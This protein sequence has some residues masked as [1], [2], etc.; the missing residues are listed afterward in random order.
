[1]NGVCLRMRPPAS[2]NAFSRYFLD[3]AWNR[4]A[5]R[6]KNNSMYVNKANCFLAGHLLSRLERNLTDGA[7]LRAGDD[8]PQ[9][10][11]RPGSWS[12]LSGIPSVGHEDRRRN[13]NRSRSRGAQL[14]DTGDMDDPAFSPWCLRHTRGRLPRRCARA[15]RS[16]SL[17]TAALFAAPELLEVFHKL[18]AHVWHP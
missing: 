11:G 9:R 7:E 18:G 8:G 10:D 15:G 16:R 4:T 17:D 3:Q 6:F 13:S 2:S 1:M 12:G 5:C 14:H